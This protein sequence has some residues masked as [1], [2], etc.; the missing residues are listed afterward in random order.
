MWSLIIAVILWGLGN[1]LLKVARLSMNT[2]SVQAAQV[3]GVMLGVI[4]FYMFDRN[5]LDSFS[6]QLSG[7]MLSFLAGI[8]G[9]VGT[10]FFLYALG[11]EKVSFA[12]QFSSLHIIVATILGIFFLK[13]TLHVG[14]IIGGLLMIGGAILLGITR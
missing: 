8:S 4:L 5:N 10:Y 14:E 2:S 6:K 1:F 11:N 3:V 13:E 9:F 7:Y 12:S